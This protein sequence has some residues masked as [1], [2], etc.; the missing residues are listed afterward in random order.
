MTV[1]L[2]R[3]QMGSPGHV[4]RQSEA[5]PRSVAWAPWKTNLEPT[6]GLEAGLGNLTRKGQGW[7]DP[8]DRV[9]PLRQEKGAVGW[10]HG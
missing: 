1:Q 9:D 5:R 2:Q 7:P 10:N 6:T 4:S 3:I 8:T